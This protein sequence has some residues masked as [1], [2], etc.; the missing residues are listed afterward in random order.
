MTVGI[1]QR[2][3][4]PQVVIGIG[5]AEESVG[6]STHQPASLV[7]ELVGSSDGINDFGNALH[8]VVFERRC[9]SHGIR[10]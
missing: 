6:R 2:L 1:G 7:R 3:E 4:Q 10:D 5:G 8:R 9:V